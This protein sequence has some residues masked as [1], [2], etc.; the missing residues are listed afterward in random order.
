MT[1]LAL[2]WIP[3]KITTPHK[4]SISSGTR[5]SPIWMRPTLICILPCIGHKASRHPTLF[6]SPIQQT[7][8][9]DLAKKLTLHRCRVMDLNQM[10]LALAMERFKG[11]PDRAPSRSNHRLNRSGRTIHCD[12]VKG[13]SLPL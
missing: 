5:R 4:V 11:P 9:T 10:L 12:L 2:V 1:P 6:S 3:G 8:V 7:T 13:T